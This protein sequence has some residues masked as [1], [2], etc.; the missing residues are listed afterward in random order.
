M[1]EMNDDDDDRSFSLLFFLVWCQLCAKFFVI[2][3]RTCCCCPIISDRAAGTLSVLMPNLLYIPLTGRVVVVNSS[4]RFR[5]S[6][7]DWK[8][9][10]TAHQIS[11]VCTE[12]SASKSSALLPDGAP[13]LQAADQRSNKM[14][15]LFFLFF[16][17]L[18]LLLYI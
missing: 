12:Y 2:N 3:T 17:S 14:F 15:I 13:Y 6:T 5:L 16:F 11:A 8:S 7:C 9:L 1:F 18:V 4:S 10:Q